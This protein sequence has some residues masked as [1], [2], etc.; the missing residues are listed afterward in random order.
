MPI[1][2]VYILENPK[3]P[4]FV[5]V[6]MTGD[7]PQSRAE[8]ISRGTGVVGRWEVAGWMIVEDMQAVEYCAHRELSA[9]QVQGGGFEIFE[10]S[11]A[12]ACA[13]LERAAKL[14]Q[15]EVLKNN[16]PAVVAQERAR[17]QAAEAAA[18]R[19]QAEAQAA[20]LRHT[21]AEAKLTARAQAIA[22]AWR[23]HVKPRRWSLSGMLNS[24]TALLSNRH[25]T[26]IRSMLVWARGL[27]PQALRY[28]QTASKWG[29]EPTTER[30][31]TAARAYG[32]FAVPRADQMAHIIRIITWGHEQA[33]KLWT[34]IKLITGWRSDY[35]REHVDFVLSML[36]HS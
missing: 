12:H 4:G 1:G 35:T 34:A 28:I 31:A 16:F 30:V 15:L 23:E 9:V 27:N 32:Y 20:M 18:L 22:D 29:S 2:Y 11:A 17:Q 25:V 8:E 24:S 14:L 7:H 26:Y 21:D 10:C 5:K 13:A 6:G 33:M 19:Q 36:H 3:T